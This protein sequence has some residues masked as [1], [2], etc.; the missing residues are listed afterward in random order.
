MN[1]RK[2]SREREAMVQRQLVKR[3]IA[4]A[5]VLA[6]MGQV[7]REEF[8]LA[9]NRDLAYHDRAV[10]IG[11]Q[12]TISQPFIVALMSEAI[13]DQP[14]KSVLEIGT[15]CGYQTAVLSLLAEQ[16]DTVEIVE[17]LYQEAKQRL[18]Q[19]N[20]SNV[21]CHLADGS[22]GWPSSAPYDAILVAAAPAEVPPALFDQL[23]P[24]GRLV[25]PVGSDSQTLKLY[26]RRADGR[27]FQRSLSPVAFVP[28]T[29]QAQGHRSS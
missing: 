27:M 24:G 10:P 7:P 8:M 16:V 18:A 1:E 20:Y 15:G 11:H 26:E 2:W 22:F 4:H 9:T 6:A 29:G 3:G 14:R 17:P 25:I 28:M 13:F 19:L 5:E 23:A 12:Q 21:R